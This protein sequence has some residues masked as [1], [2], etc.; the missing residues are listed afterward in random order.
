MERIIPKALLD[1]LK[2]SIKDL[3]DGYEYASELNRVLNSDD[4]QLNLSSKEISRLKDFAEDVKKVGEINHYTEERIK[5]I[6][7]EHFGRGGILKFLGINSD[8]NNDT[9]PIWPF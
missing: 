2:N 8:S 7:T 3:D 4:C 1:F 9:K 6:E 5:N